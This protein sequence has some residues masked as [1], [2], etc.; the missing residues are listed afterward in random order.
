LNPGLNNRRINR[1]LVVPV[2]EFAGFQHVIVGH[3]LDG[4]RAHHV[5][6]S[7]FYVGLCNHA[8]NQA[9]LHIGLEN[10][11]VYLRSDYTFITSII[12]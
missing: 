8:V 5:A 2:V 10:R 9:P 3:V 1:P 4:F 12:I 11:T 7:I 6:L